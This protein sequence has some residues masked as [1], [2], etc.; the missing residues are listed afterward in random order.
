[1]PPTTMQ[2]GWAIVTKKSL[3]ALSLAAFAKV[4]NSRHCTPHWSDWQVPLTH[5]QPK[6][7]NAARKS[8][9]AKQRRAAKQRRKAKK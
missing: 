3:F 2:T 8:S 7:R 1:M 4:F 9:V 5:Q 6:Y